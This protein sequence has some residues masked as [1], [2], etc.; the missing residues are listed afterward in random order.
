MGEGH[1]RQRIKHVG[2]L[3]VRNELDVLQAGKNTRWLEFLVR[4][5][6][7]SNKATEMSM[8]K[9]TFLD[10]IKVS[11]LAEFDNGFSIFKQW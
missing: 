7:E 5:K 10:H 11:E 8:A 1:P 9:R 3:W 2:G 4:E 6:V